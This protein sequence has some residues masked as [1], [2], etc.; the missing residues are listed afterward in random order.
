[1]EALAPVARAPHSLAPDGTEHVGALLVREAHPLFSVQPSMRWYLKSDVA[2]DSKTCRFG[3]IAYLCYLLPNS[4]HMGDVGIL[5]TGL[6]NK[7]ETEKEPK[8]LP[9]PRSYHVARRQSRSIISQ[10]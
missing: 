6:E 5:S 3:P 4:H 1:M 9:S 8:I 7:L 10:M 2:E